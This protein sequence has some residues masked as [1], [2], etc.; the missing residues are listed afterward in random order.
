MRRRALSLAGV[1]VLLVPTG[2]LAMPPVS[3][4][5]M[6]RAKADAARELS[7]AVLPLGSTRVR[8][9]QSVHPIPIT[10]G[11]DCTKKDVAEDHGFWRAPGS[12]ATVGAWIQ[13]H[14]PM[15]GRSSTVAV[16]MGN[17]EIGW[18]VT[19]AFPDQPSV[20]RRRLEFSL[21]FARGGGTAIRVDAIAVGEPRPHHAPC[22]VPPNTY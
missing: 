8:R 5:S 15:H 18:Y 19:V 7:S 10:L 9:D 13:K 3:Q 20:T 14:P 16:E 2:A 1:L 21:A 6:A 12:P 22:Y 11:I 17:G 4:Q